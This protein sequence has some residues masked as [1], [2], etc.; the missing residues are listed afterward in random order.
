MCYFCYSIGSENLCLCSFL[1]VKSTN[2][3]SWNLIQITASLSAWPAVLCTFHPVFRHLVKFFWSLWVYHPD[4][5]QDNLR[6][7]I[8]SFKKP[9]DYLKKCV[10]CFTEEKNPN[11]HFHS[12]FRPSYLELQWVYPEIGMDMTSQTATH[13]GLDIWE[14]SVRFMEGNTS[15]EKQIQN[16]SGSSPDHRKFDVLSGTIQ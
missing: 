7:K 13:W 8:K 3:C 12:F 14:T 15:S 9:K 16:G 5:I 1:R 10:F 2:W 11:V 4:V 6:L